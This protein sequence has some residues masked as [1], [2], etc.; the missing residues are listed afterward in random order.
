MILQV[1]ML[2]KLDVIMT[3]IFLGEVRLD[4]V[5]KDFHKVLDNSS[6]CILIYS[7][8]TKSLLFQN[9]KAK[10]MLTIKPSEGL[11]KSA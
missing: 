10:E 11:T 4:H 8:E 2:F 7:R 9:E 1:I 3:R 5:N 6:Q